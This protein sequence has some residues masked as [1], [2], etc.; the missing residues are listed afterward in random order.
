MKDKGKKIVISEI[1]PIS[2]LTLPKC[3]KN[4]GFTITKIPV[5]SEGFIDLER[6]KETRGQ[7][8]NSCKFV[9]G[10]PR[11]W[12]NTTNQRSVKNS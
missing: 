10:K 4:S 12:N 2:V 5:D 8:N 3:F 6:L 7:R 9:G 11:N 1:E